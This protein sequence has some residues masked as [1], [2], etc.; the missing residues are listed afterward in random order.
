MDC[1]FT[2]SRTVFEAPSQVA[3]TIKSQRSMAA[4]GPLLVAIV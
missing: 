3:E 1:S 4:N 2:I